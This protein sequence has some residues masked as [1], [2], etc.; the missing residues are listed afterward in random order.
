LVSLS[1]SL[2]PS[3]LTLVQVLGIC[4]I[5]AAPGSRVLEFN[6]NVV[7]SLSSLIII[8]AAAL[9]LPT[10]LYSTFPN[11]VDLK[12][13][14]LSFSR[15]TAGVLLLIYIAYLYFQFWTHSDLFMDEEDDVKE[16]GEASRI[17]SQETGEATQSQEIEGAQ[18]SD[19]PSASGEQE[20]DMPERSA[21]EV[22]L[23]TAALVG[24][25]AAVVICT[26]FFIDK[27]D[28]T[29]NFFHV[30]KTF[31]A[32]IVIPFASNAPEG[33]TVI[34]ASQK[35]HINF[36]IGVIVG[37]ILQIALFV[38]PILVVIGWLVGQPMTLYFETSQTCILFLSV[39]V[40]NNLLQDGK[41]TYLHGV[42]LLST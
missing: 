4:L 28:E 19:G 1:S 22:Y 21:R 29:A 26:Y 41:Y 37:S 9:I 33:S 38:L 25:A 42:M 2:P 10:M 16:Q 6:Q 13:M 35:E 20:V 39:L 12:D 3:S 30:T 15:A 31:V 24:S 14:I 40:V 17:Q 23:A 8:A 18:A 36:A 11:T 27:L 32:L 34:A 5:A 7:D